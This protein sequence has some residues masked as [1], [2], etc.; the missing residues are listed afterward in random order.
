MLNV[1]ST[2]HKLVLQVVARLFNSCYLPL[3]V[4]GCAYG[5]AVGEG[6]DGYNHD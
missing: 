1:G 5:R 2:I 4:N 6:G 3:S